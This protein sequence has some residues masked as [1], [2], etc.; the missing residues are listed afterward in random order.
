MKNF[1]MSYQEALASYKSGTAAKP[2]IRI[3][4][5]AL[6]TEA[7]GSSRLRYLQITPWFVIDY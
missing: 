6:E 5:P 2:D 7:S 4:V 3:S 1:F